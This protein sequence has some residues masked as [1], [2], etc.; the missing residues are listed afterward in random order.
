MFISQKLQELLDSTLPGDRELTQREVVALFEAANN[1]ADFGQK[2][3]LRR[4]LFLRKGDIEV[5]TH[6]ENRVP[7]QRTVVTVHH[8]GN[9]RRPSVP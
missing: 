9:G 7:P 3:W 1:E 5:R 4:P 2:F 6:P 8:P